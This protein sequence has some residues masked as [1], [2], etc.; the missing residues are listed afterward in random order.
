VI[1][2]YNAE[3]TVGFAVDSVLCQ[4]F[5]DFELIVIDDGSTDRTAQVVKERRDERLR[6]VT[7][8]NSGVST[9]R[10]RGVSLTSAPLVAF[11]D[12]DD[13]WSPTKLEHQVAALRTGPSIGLC[14]TTAEFVDDELRKLGEDRALH[15][16][17]YAAALLIKGNV[18]SGSSSSVMVRRSLVESVGGFDP[19][20]SQCA[21]WDL[22]LR[23]SVATAFEPLDEPLV[24]YRKA[25]G[26]MSSDPALLERDTFALLDKFFSSPSSG[27]YQRLRRRAYGRQ[28][29]VCSGTYLH[30]GQPREATRCLTRGLRTDP[31]TVRRPLMLPARSLARVWS[32]A[33]G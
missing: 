13:L 4:T 30:A 25:P 21:D 24:R 1:P 11:L 16:A 26:T 18:I 15:Y 33:R 28:W 20:F 31:W 19:A 9:A 7:G 3:R 2:A 17:D 5:D 27:E 12:A 32:R 10:N 29:M 6:C 14:F 8:S 23:L 22:W